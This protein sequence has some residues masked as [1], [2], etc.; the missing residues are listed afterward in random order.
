MK[1]AIAGYGAEGESNYRYYNT[2]DNQLVIVDERQPARAV[3]VD[4]SLIVGE[5][6]F[7]KLDGYDLVI[8]TAGLPPRNI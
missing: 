4:A 6:A 3:P 7:A 8:R 1:I 5:S 2:P